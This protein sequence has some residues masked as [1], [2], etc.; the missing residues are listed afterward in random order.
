M[1]TQSIRTS[2]CVVFDICKRSCQPLSDLIFQALQSNNKT[3]LLFTN[4]CSPKCP[5]FSYTFS[6]FLLWLSCIMH[7]LF[8]KIPRKVKTAFVFVLHW[9][10]LILYYQVGRREFQHV[11]WKWGAELGCSPEK[12]DRHR[13]HLHVVAQSRG[14]QPLP[15][16]LL[17]PLSS[18]WKPHEQT[19]E[20]YWTG[21]RVH[22]AG[23][24]LNLDQAY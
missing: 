13:G 6:P 12:E 22:D 19:Q 9:L 23:T 1:P 7:L 10:L 8:T 5:G 18:L 16:V 17:L 3:S 4:R 15:G 2:P 14:K 21:E 20:R 24:I 11:R